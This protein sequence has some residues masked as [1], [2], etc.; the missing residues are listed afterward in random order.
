MPWPENFCEGH[1][2]D[3]TLMDTVPD[4]YDCVCFYH[5][6]NQDEV[7]G[8]DCC[9]PGLAYDPS[10]GTCDWIYNIEGCDGKI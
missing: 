4:P 7:S 2:G 9:Q 3:G 5:C 6:N 1:S 8:H 10:T